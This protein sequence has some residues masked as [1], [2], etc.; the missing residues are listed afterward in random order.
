MSS[1]TSFSAAPTVPTTSS[2]GF[3]IGLG[4][5]VPVPPPGIFI[6]PGPVGIPPQSAPSGVPGAFG[7]VLLLSS[8]FRL[9]RCF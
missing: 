4:P 2:S 7:F 9:L 5:G 6:P 1:T 3:S 8:T